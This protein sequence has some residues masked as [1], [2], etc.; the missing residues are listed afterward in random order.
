MIF[1]KKL[2]Q[3]E[4]FTMDPEYSLQDVVRCDLC[5]SPVPK[6]HCEFCHINFC[7]GCSE[8]HLQDN[9]NI[10]KVVSFKQRYQLSDYLTCNRVV[11]TECTPKSDNT[12][13]SIISL[14]VPSDE[15]KRNKEH[16]VAIDMSGAFENQNEFIKRNF[17]ESDITISEISEIQTSKTDAA[18]RTESNA[19]SN[20]QNNCTDDKR[21]DALYTFEINIINELCH[22]CNYVL[23]GMLIACV[24]SLIITILEII[25]YA[26]S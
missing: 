13:T 16:A 4:S 11:S 8:K 1:F 3:M 19:E 20:Q 25:F 23:Y 14:C 12:D 5:D 15:H 24:L 18:D 2:G 22:I 21:S 9:S 7:N 17:Q 10:H 6:L 26:I